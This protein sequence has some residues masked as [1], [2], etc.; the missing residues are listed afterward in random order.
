[1]T[2]IKKH[3]IAYL[4]RSPFLRLG[5]I[6]Q[7]NKFSRYKVIWDTSTEE[8]FGRNLE[9]K[10][11]PE[12]VIID[13]TNPKIE[14]FETVKFLKKEYPDI[15]ILILSMLGMEVAIKKM[16]EMGINGFV[17]QQEDYSVLK[18]A[19]DK[20]IKNEKYLSKYIDHTIQRNKESFYE[21]VKKLDV[22]AEEIQFIELSCGD[23]THKDIAK[24]MGCSISKIGKIRDRLY[25]RFNIKTR[26]GMVLF[27]VKNGFLF[28]Y[29]FS[30]NIKKNIISIN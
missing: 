11:K 6:E 29:G 4:D 3:S 7:I 8:E 12:I 24:I 5:I 16:L 2:G 22:T 15:K 26:S 27:A 19:L 25:K 13:I 9:V 23:S 1:M 18:D 21:K 10:E 20:I 28:D 14:G 30:A 17:L